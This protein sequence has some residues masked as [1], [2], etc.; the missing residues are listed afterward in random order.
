M[1][2][3]EKDRKHEERIA[4]IFFA[5]MAAV[6]A[7]AVGRNTALPSPPP[8]RESEHKMKTKELTV[9][10]RWEQGIEHDPRS[11]ALYKSIA[12]IDYKLGGDSFGFKSGGDGDNGENLMY[13]FDIHF[14]RL[15]K[16]KP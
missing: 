16:V 5:M 8:P 4:W 11:K 10:Q 3:D 7:F 14:A 12:D 13:L 2:L 9:D 1:I 6:L 15:D